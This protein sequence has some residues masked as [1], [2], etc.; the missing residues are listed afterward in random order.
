[1]GCL[2]M[3]QITKNNHFTNLKIANRSNICCMKGCHAKGEKQDDSAFYSNRS[4]HKKCRT[5][6]N[7]Y[8]R[9]ADR[10]HREQLRDAS[11][12]RWWL[13][14]FFRMSRTEMRNAK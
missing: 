14:A 13:E 5:C 10:K 7:E 2:A 4:W 1:M 3:V 12:G 8:V 9:N 6:R 11:G